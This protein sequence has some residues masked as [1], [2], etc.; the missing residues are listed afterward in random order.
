VNTTMPLM[1]ALS[2]DIRQSIRGLGRTPA[3]T[4]IAVGTVALGIPWGASVNPAL[5]AARVDFSMVLRAD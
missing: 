4:A 5:R 1:D 3:I 2:R